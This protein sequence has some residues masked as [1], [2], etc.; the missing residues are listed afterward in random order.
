[1][2]ALWLPDLQRLTMGLRGAVHETQVQLE[3]AFPAHSGHCMAR[4]TPCLE[5]F[6]RLVVTAFART[7]VFPYLVKI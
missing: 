1:M 7:F 2:S 5:G 6:I 3:G 4:V